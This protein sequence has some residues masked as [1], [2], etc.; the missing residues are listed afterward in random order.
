MMNFQL[1]AGSANETAHL[2]QGAGL[3]AA[4]ELK[5]LVPEIVGTD[6]HGTPNAD[7]ASRSARTAY[8]MGCG[9]FIGPT[10]IADID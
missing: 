2:A 4:G 1:L 9:T 3:L 7:L 10:C 6:S 8:G 5:G